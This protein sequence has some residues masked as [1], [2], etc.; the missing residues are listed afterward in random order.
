MKTLTGDI[1]YPRLKREH[2]EGIVEL[3]KEEAWPSYL[4]AERT[5]RALTAPGVVT[6]VAVAG[7]QVVGFAYLQTDGEIQAH[8]TLIAV[9]PSYRL[10][11]IGRRLVDEAFRESGAQYLNLVSTEGADDFYRSFAYRD[12]PGFRIYPAQSR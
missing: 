3:C 1:N 11:G 8:L 6:I 2:L 7:E 12:F 5:W 4:D 9:R 10:R